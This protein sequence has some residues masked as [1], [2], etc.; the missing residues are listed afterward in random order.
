EDLKTLFRDAA[1]R[2]HPDLMDDEAGRGPAEA[3]MKR[4]NPAYQ[5]GDAEAI[6]NLVRQWETSPYAAPG[7]AQG[8]APALQAAVAHAE[9]RLA[10]ARDSDLAR[11][12]ED[13]FSAAIDGRDLLAE[14]REQAEVALARAR[15]RLAELD[16]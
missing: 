16:N 7:A 5:R 14:L 9:Q 11:L 13:S 10:E 8:P 15:A 3:F 6:G 4:L 12:M 2:M 1:K